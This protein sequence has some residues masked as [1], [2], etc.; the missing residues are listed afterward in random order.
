[1]EKQIK[2]RQIMVRPVVA[3]GRTT[4]VRDLA[5]QMFMGGF[6]G[7]PVAERSGRLVG[8]VTEFDLIRAIR[9][10]KPV[11]STQAQDVMTTDVICVDAN[12]DV[13]EVMEVMETARVIRVPVTSNGRLVGVIARP[14]VLRAFVE[15]NFMEF[16]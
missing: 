14:D 16:S 3:V 4:T 5:I 10:G 7:M 1:M 9:E 13:D 11:D 8:I 6:S 2:A 12:A 15:P